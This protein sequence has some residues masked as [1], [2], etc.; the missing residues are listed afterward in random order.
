MYYKNIFYNF[1]NIIFG[2]NITCYNCGITVLRNDEY[3]LCDKCYIDFINEKNCYYFSFEPANNYAEFNLKRNINPENSEVFS[4]FEFNG[5]ARKLLLDLKFNYQKENSK[6]IANTISHEVGKLNFDLISCVPISKSSMLER[7]FN[8]SLL[9]AQELS[10]IVGIPYDETIL[11]R[12]K[13][14]KHQVGLSKKDR[15]LN[16]KDSFKANRNIKNKKILVIDD[17]LTTGATI[18]NCRKVLLEAGAIPLFFTVCYTEL[19]D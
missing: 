1:F 9:I 7:G 10:R 2:K 15:I 11:T 16:I 14:N 18:F 8:Q 5:I 6:I 19:I 17:I 4:L 12:S 3:M 13:N